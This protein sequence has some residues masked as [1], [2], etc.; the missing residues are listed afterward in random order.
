MRLKIYHNKFKPSIQLPSTP[1][2]S[3]VIKVQPLTEVGDK[4]TPNKM[5]GK[6]PLEEVAV[7][8]PMGDSTDQHMLMSSRTTKVSSS[9]V[10]NNTHYS[11]RVNWKFEVS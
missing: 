10:T 2:S 8:V 1:P 6:S 4:G 5:K 9:L 7:C 11:Y 3:N